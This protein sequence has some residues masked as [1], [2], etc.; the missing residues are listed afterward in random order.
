MARLALSRSLTLGI[1][2]AAAASVSAQSSQQMS[3]DSSAGGSLAAVTT[4][5]S[6]IATETVATDNGWTATPIFTVGESIGSYLPVGILDGVGIFPGGPGGANAAVYVNHELNPGNG[7]PY[8]LANGTQLTGARVSIFQVRRLVDGAGNV[9]YGLER[10]GLAYEAI[11][12]RAGNMVT[13]PAQIN[14]TG[15]A[16]DGLARL[17]SAT[18]IQAGTYG[19]VDEVF[20]TNEETGV[21]FHPHGG[22]V[23]ALD[24][25]D[26]ALW[27]APALGRGAWENV[28][29][30]ATGSDDTVALLLGDDTESAPLY[31]YVGQKDA[32][33]DRSFL[34]RNGLAVGDLYAWRA[35]NGDLSPEEF[36]GLN[37]QRTGTFV[38]VTVQDPAMASMPGFDAAGY[39][40]ND[41]LTG[42]ADSLGCHSFSRPEDLHTNPYDGDQAVFASTGRGGLYPSD[43]WGIVYIV[44]VDVVALTGVLTIVHDADDLAIPDEGIRSPDN[45]CWAENGKI[46][47]QED[48][49]TSPSSL[50]GQA[51]GV[52]ASIWE[53]DPITRRRQRVG[54]IDRTVIAPAGSTDSDAGSLGA[55]ET[56]GI[57]DVTSFFQTKLNERLLLATVQAHGIEDGPI[58][59]NAL[60]DEG[61]QIVFLSKIEN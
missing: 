52:E 4:T 36:N 24:R 17:C 32:I 41:T 18:G 19:F 42:E 27:A 14:E 25:R 16:I 9:S 56:S 58:G 8:T 23:W 22:S 48:R 35:D 57:L 54:E 33:G 61:G 34:D 11:Y 39:A 20:L 49:S 5:P 38:P 31:L 60:L 51:T 1:A 26:R 43:N 53:L 37:E 45:L 55:W 21:P 47:V 40:D 10:A 7:Y 15:N 44:D 13:D 2:V 46:Y 59:G 28:T 50:F 3:T 29:P 30:I 12:D 6:M